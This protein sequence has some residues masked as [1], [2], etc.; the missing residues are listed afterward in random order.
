MSEN[1]LLK[2]YRLSKSNKINFIGFNLYRHSVYNRNRTEV[3][4]NFK[5]III[6]LILYIKYKYMF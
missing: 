4:I 3:R 6:I 2:S 5:V 1:A